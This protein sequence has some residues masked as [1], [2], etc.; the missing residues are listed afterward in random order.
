MKINGK[1]FDYALMM[2][3]ND[4]DKDYAETITM[5]RDFKKKNHKGNKSTKELQ[6]QFITENWGKLEEKCPNL[7][8]NCNLLV[9]IWITKK[10][11]NEY[12]LNKISDEMTKTYEKL[13]CAENAYNKKEAEYLN[14]RYETLIAFYDVVLIMIKN[15]GLN[16][17]LLMTW[18][19]I[20][21]GE[22]PFEMPNGELLFLEVKDEEQ[23]EKLITIYKNHNGRLY[24]DCNGHITYV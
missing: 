7:I 12:L 23:K 3:A 13:W 2:C 16:L 1:I 20:L 10:D 24:E 15:N 21:N 22:I 4:D 6:L 11:P 5:Y 9:D 19:R 8:Y 18:H 17:H 14:M